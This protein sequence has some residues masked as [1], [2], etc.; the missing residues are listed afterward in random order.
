MSGG[1]PSLT[2][3]DVHVWWLYQGAAAECAAGELAARLSLT[4]LGR[5]A[6]LRSRRARCAYIARRAGVRAVLAA[7]LGCADNTVV[8]ARTEAGRE[9]IVAPA[10]DD[11]DFSVSSSR[12][13]ALIA[14]GRGVRVG[15]DVE[16]LGRELPWHELAAFAF[17][18]GE[19]AARTTS[20][21]PERDFLAGWTALEAGVKLAGTR[22]VDALE[23]P[24]IACERADPSRFQEVEVPDG[25]LA[26]L[27][28]NVEPHVTS[29]KGWWPGGR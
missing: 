23:A 20:G 16:V 10:A 29:V 3:G 4:E 18:G 5:A 19:R 26:T 15:V 14:V 21:T 17:R 8:L 13:L 7:Y 22:L 6:S 9:W 27:A 2:T 24:P 12:G 11:L 25:Y 28:T 1:T